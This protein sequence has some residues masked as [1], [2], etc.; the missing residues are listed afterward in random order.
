MNNRSPR[1]ADLSTPKPPFSLNRSFTASTVCLLKGKPYEN[2]DH[3]FSILKDVPES[4][5]LVVLPHMPFLEC[6]PAGMARTTIPFKQFARKRKI[7]MALS[8]VE[9]AGGGKYHTALLIDDKGGILGAQRKTHRLFNDDMKTGDD[10]PVF[11][12]SLGKI[13]LTIGTD[14]YFP[15]IYEVLKMRGAE[16]ITWHSYPEPFREHSAWMP[17]LSA[18]CIDSRCHLITAM[19]A[20]EKTYLPNRYKEGWPGSPWGRS[21]V[22]NRVGVPL[23]DT[24]Y[25]E[26]CASARIFLDKRK[27]NVFPDDPRDE[28]IFIV[29]S[30]GDRKSL[31]PITRT[32]R[33]L[34]APAIARRKRQC[35]IAVATVFPENEIG[36]EKIPEAIINI[37]REAEKIK[38]DLLIFTEQKCRIVNKTTDDILRRIGQTA[39]KLNCYIAMGGIT[40]FNCTSVCHLWDRKGRLVYEQPIFWP[41]EDQI[42]LKVFDTDFGRIGAHTCGD[43]WTP[44]LDRILAL[45]GAEIIID[46]SHMCG[47][48][49]GW[50]ETML[51]ARAIDSSAWV[52]VSHSNSSDPSLRSL[53]IDPHGQVVSASQ[54]N[55]CGINYCDIHLDDKRFYYEGLAKN[56]PSNGELGMS[57][58]FEGTLPLQ[59]EGWKD[60]VFSAR[61]PELY[62]IIPTT[63]EVI[64]RHRGRAGHVKTMQKKSKVMIRPNHPLYS[65]RKT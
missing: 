2:P 10:L 56:Q 24:G 38:P 4:A 23:A 7:H 14:F 16:I 65:Q 39:K 63:N 55:R 22:L 59:K 60:A 15:E 18:R 19:Y 58:Y 35:R 61:R 62:G 50:N 34:N 5:K 17:L 8:L 57:A 42:D 11:D 25:A 6:A 29:S 46:P 1:S 3:L 9:R 44:L 20:D 51:R 43:L 30:Y 47:P 48:D 33:Q 37:F 12:T 40:N 27:K 41:Y 54:F 49:G 45:K 21:M 31:S 32:H 28:N 52:A 26:G 36:N 13:G 53:I 64:L